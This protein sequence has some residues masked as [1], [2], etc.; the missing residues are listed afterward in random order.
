MLIAGIDEAG[1]G[2]VIGP[3]V[4]CGAVLNKININNKNKNNKIIG[5]VFVNV[6]DSKKLSKNKREKIYNVLK[7]RVEFAI[8][9]V[10]PWELDKLMER[11]TINDILAR[12]YAEV[13]KRLKPEIVYV[14]CPDVKPQRLKERL[15]RETGIKV[16]AMHNAER[17]PIVAVASI[18]AKV[19][20]DKEIDKLKEEYGDLGSG[21]PSDKKTIKFIKNCIES[22]SLPKIIRKK[23]K[24]VK[25]LKQRE[26]GD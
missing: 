24:T 16:I 17:I 4:V 12:C 25:L 10:E 26:L 9:K 11:E 5:D 22:G 18:I 13:I 23:W 19:E 7:E 15:E 2:S 21:Y 20:R 8:L 1:K 14:D 3:L 6:R